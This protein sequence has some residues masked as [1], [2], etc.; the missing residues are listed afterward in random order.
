MA[1]KSKF[2]TYGLIN[3]SLVRNRTKQD[4]N[5]LDLLKAY[6]RMK[7]Q[8]ATNLASNI[9]KLMTGE[10]NPE[11]PEGI[12]IAMQAASLAGTG[13]VAT[14]PSAGMGTLGMFMGKRSLTFDKNAANTAARMQAEGKT[15]LE[16]LQATG[17]RRWK[18]G[19]RQEINDSKAAFTS[20]FQ[21]LPFQNTK[22]IEALD[23]PDL[24]KGYPGLADVR[25]SVRDNLGMGEAAFD[26]RSNTIYISKQD[27][28]I[29]EVSPMLHEIQH[30]IQEFEGWPKGGTQKTFGPKELDSNFRS[31]NA[32]KNRPFLSPW[33]QYERLIGETEARATQRRKDY[34]DEQRRTIL[35]EEDFTYMDSDVRIPLKDLNVEEYFNNLPD[36]D[37]SK[38]IR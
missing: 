28:A 38:L 16:I 29:G 33:E 8:D 1:D 19:D 22:L 20:G 31:P 24:Y 23:H 10:I 6:G 18:S 35:P 17:T 13:G 26:P 34:T 9:E 27:L 5:V 32:K 21:D 3:K 2:T 14:A 30:W 36:F 7:V 12:A 15:P 37:M 4:R 11:S 25:V